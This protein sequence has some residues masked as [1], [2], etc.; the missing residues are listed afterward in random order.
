[1]AVT[2]AAPG[3]LKIAGSLEP[4]LSPVKQAADNLTPI[5]IELGRYACNIENFG[6]VARSMTGFGGVGNGPDGGL[7]SFRLQIG[8][9][10]PA[11]VLGL[12]GVAGLGVRDKYSPPC[13][14]LATKYPGL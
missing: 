3:I 2:P 9:A 10:D 11:H 7:G 12:T 1:M 8:I 5:L 4:L 6:A 14:Y 13:S